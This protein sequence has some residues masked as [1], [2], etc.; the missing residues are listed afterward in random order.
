MKKSEKFPFRVICDPNLPEA[1]TFV[2]RKAALDL[3]FDK[4]NSALKNYNNNKYHKN[5]N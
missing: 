5:N 3:I 4:L 1:Q 2:G